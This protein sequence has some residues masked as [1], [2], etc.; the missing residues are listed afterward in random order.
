MQGQPRDL[1]FQFVSREME[2]YR[3]LSRRGE[4]ETE[5]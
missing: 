4:F 5:I 1:G 3:E 2:K